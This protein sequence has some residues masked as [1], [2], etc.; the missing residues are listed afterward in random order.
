M[1]IAY[2]RPPLSADCLLSGP[3]KATLLAA[4][5][6]AKATA[7]T[8]DSLRNGN[9]GVIPAEQGIKSGHQG[10]LFAGSGVSDVGRDFIARNRVSEHLHTMSRGAE[11]M[12]FTQAVGDG[13]RPAFGLIPVSEN[14]KREPYL[15]AIIHLPSAELFLCA[16]LG[17]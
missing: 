17:H 14:R 11:K 5:L 7:Y 13:G 12:R 8:T 1:R 3:S 2:R 9:R 10:S 4:Y 15:S 16:P 6:R